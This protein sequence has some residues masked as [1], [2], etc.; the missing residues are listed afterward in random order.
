MRITRAKTPASPKNSAP[1]PSAS[2]STKNPTRRCSAD[3]WNIR[4]KLAPTTQA[5]GVFVNGSVLIFNYIFP[6]PATSASFTETNSEAASTISRT[7]S[8]HQGVS[9][10]PGFSMSNFKRFRRASYFLLDS[11]PKKDQFGGTG[12]D[13]RLVYR[14]ISRAN[15]KSSHRGL[16]PK[17]S[18]KTFNLTD[19]PVRRRRRQRARSRPASKT[20][21]TPRL[22]RRSP[23]ANRALAAQ[24]A[25]GRHFGAF[26]TNAVCRQ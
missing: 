15:T 11:A 9:C 19:A 16:R 14:E 10:R 23:R 24:I 5:V 8:R 21:Q 3:A 26:S 2:I 1:G 7:I 17:T 22:L 20:R 13:V 6:R 12:K 18:A 25:C 4:R